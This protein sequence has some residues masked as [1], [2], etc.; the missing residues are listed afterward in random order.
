MLNLGSFA[1]GF[2]AFMLTIPVR[3]E[4]LQY[5]CVEGTACPSG[6]NGYTLL[7]WENILGPSRRRSPCA[8][9]A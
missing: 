6:T 8:D 3:V 4:F 5:D 7:G 9:T 1:L 2:V